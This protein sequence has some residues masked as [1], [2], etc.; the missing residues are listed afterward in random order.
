MMVE[1]SGVAT[2]SWVQRAGYAWVRRSQRWL[3]TIGGVPFIW[4]LVRRDFNSTGFH[5]A[6]LLLIA[7]PALATAWAAIRLRCSVCKIPVYGH[8]L[9]GF[10]RGKERRGFDELPSCPYCL[11][12]GTGQTGDASRVDSRKESTAAIRHGLVAIG[13]FVGLLAVVFLLMLLGWF[14]GYEHV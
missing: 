14:P 4:F 12:D 7:V 3:I 2:S 9:L 1:R 5:W 13:V 6:L 8:W 11:D 10:P